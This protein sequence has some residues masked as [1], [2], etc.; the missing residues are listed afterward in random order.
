MASSKN[1]EIWSF[2]D[3]DGTLIKRDS[4]LPFL[5]K[6]KLKH[7]QRILPLFF[8]PLKLLNFYTKNKEKSYLKE[9][10]L[11]AFMKGSKK[12]D[13][14]RFVKDFWR[15]FLIKNQNDVLVNKLKWHSKNGHRV[16]IVTGSFDFYAEYLKNIWP[17]NG[18]I[19][20]RA[21]WSGDLLTGKIFG[22]NCKGKEKKARIEGELGIKLC[23]VEY[24]AYTDSHSDCHLLKNAKFPVIIKANKWFR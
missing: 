23:N 17:I 8:I 2:F 6:W 24:Y 14:D 20:T 19:A 9:A 7:P 18:V 22:K 12:S 4:Y 15:S 11:Y 3:L 5:F 16:Y 13:I 10:F 1:R 21:E